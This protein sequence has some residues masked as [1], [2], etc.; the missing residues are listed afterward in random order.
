M[1]L[2]GELS[3]VLATALFIFALY[4]MN[5]PKTARRGVIAGVVGMTVAVLATWIQPEIIHHAWIVGAIALGFVVGVPLSRVPLTAVP[6]RTALSHAFGGLAA[7]LVGTA[8][9]FLWRGGS[10]TAEMTHFRMS[11]LAA[12]VILGF[13]TFTGSLMAAGKLQEVR[14]I[15][16]RPVTYPG[17]NFVNIGV[18]AIAVGLGVAVAVHPGAPWAQQA[19]L[20]I[21]ALALIFGVLLIIPIGGAD[22]PTVISIL[23]AYAGLSA[24]AM[25]FVLDSKLLVTAGALDGSSGLI[26]SIIM[27]RAMNRSFTNV[28]FG[29]FGKAQPA[30]AAG[31]QK[32]WKQETVEGAAQLLEQARNVVIIPGYGMAVAQAQHKVREL[33]DALTKRG[34]IVKFAIHPVAGRMPGHM[35]VLLAEANIPYSALVEMDEINPEMPQTDVALVLGANDVVNPAARYNKGTPIYGMPI[36]DA[37]KAKTVLAVKRSKKPGF[38]GIDNELYVQDNTWM[39]FGDAKAVLSDLVKQFGSG[40][41]H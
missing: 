27:C 19:F 10:A 36:I 23:N 14:W 33:Y 5:D 4:W 16:Q 39:L 18:L 41:I 34:I 22:M 2:V 24:V 12:E 20:V 15:P 13:L 28:L 11:A 17:Q 29:A 31:E 21:A 26:L 37:D 7:G 3:A 8:E 30:L 40:G 1:H 35:N 9:Y 32:E 25:G 38:A 6:Q